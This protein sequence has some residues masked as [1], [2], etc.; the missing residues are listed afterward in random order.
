MFSLYD[1]SFLCFSPQTK[2]KPFLDINTYHDYSENIYL[3]LNA[4]GSFIR[5]KK[6]SINVTFAIFCSSKYHHSDP[7]N[8]NPIQV[9]VL[10]YF[11]ILI[12]FFPSQGNSF[13]TLFIWSFQSS[14]NRNSIHQLMLVA[15]M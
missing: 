6:Q 11:L 14:R 8:L 7:I 15:R 2:N 9:F 3:K 10:A 1:N 13:F 4:G 5:G 12:E